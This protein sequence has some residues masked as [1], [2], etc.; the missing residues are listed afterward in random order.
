[1]W[2]NYTLKTDAFAG[3]WTGK[4][5]SMY[6]G[7]ERIKERVGEERRLFQAPVHAQQNQIKH[8]VL[9]LNCRTNTNVMI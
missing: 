4:A 3:L 9:I 5:R 6:E 8:T 2:L 1:M 7:K